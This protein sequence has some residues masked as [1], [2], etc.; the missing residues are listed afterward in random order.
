MIRL[1][2]LTDY[3]VVLMVELAQTEDIATAGLLARKTGI[4]Q[5]TVAKLL[6]LLTQGHLTR[7]H[8]GPAG[9]YGL[10]RTAADISVAEIIDAV[11]GP[12]AVALCAEGSLDN[13]DFEHIC[14]M[15]G[16]WD[17]VNRVIRQALHKMSLAE[18]ARADISLFDSFDEGTHRDV[19]P[20]PS[21]S[22]T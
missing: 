4:P 13:C 16:R 8:R 1:N 9:G 21:A 22:P 3:A 14:P 10:S 6:K 5:P 7:A 18:M 15:R 2:R 12:V 17:R 19:Q 20:L 11:E